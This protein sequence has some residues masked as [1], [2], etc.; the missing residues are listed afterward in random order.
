MRMMIDGGDYSLWSTAVVSFS[1]L[2]FFALISVLFTVLF[3]FLVMNGEVCVNITMKFEGTLP[4][5]AQIEEVIGS[6]FFLPVNHF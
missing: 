5:C 3:L 6:G 2:S 4:T 1:F